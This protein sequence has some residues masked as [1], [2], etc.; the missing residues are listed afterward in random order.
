[1]ARAE[2]IDVR[3]AY[4]RYDDGVEWDLRVPFGTSVRGVIER[5]RILDRFPEIDL[6]HWRVGVFGAA[7]ALDA[8]VNPGDRVEIY[9]PLRGDPKDIRRRRAARPRPS[10]A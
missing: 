3:I 2:A 8:Q 9:A 6:T 4:A 7:V 10:R 1:M 5:S